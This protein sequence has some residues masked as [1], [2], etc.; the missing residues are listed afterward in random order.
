MISNFFITRGYPLKEGVEVVNFKIPEF[1]KMKDQ[2]RI[3]RLARRI[4][5]RLERKFGGT[6]EVIGKEFPNIILF[7]PSKNVKEMKLEF[8]DGSFTA[9]PVSY[10]HLTLPTN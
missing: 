1:L 2:S 9:I 5:Y 4:G 3:H 8:V 6:F 10:T 7:R